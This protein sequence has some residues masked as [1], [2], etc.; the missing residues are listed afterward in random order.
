[1]VIHGV[2][3]E[4]QNASRLQNVRQVAA[5]EE[6]GSLKCEPSHS[7]T[8][9]AQVGGAIAKSVAFRNF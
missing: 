4:L 5:S 8:F 7:T 9:D 1:M 3:E 2:V 6:V